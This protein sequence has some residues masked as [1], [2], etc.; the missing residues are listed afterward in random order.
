MWSDNATPVTS[1][2]VPLAGDSLRKI[3]R[4]TGQTSRTVTQTCFIVN[5]S[6]NGV[7]TGVTRICQ[8]RA[9]C[10]SAGGDSGGP[11]VANDLDSP[12]VPTPCR[13]YGI[14][15]GSNGV[16]SWIGWAVNEIGGTTG[17]PSSGASG[18]CRSS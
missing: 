1:T 18:A 11:A 2:G 10:N 17:T 8:D 4:T 9:S 3:G 13:F 12:V 6:D 7:G 16:F 15:W 5:S 14:H